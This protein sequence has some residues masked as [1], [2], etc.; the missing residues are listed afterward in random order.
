[1]V[2]GVWVLVLLP[3]MNLLQYLDWAA[4]IPVPEIFDYRGSVG[5]LNRTLLA[6]AGV[7]EALIFCMGVVLLFSKERK[8][9]LN[10]LEWTRRWGVLCSYILLL[11][12]FTGILLIGSLVLVGITALFLSMPLQYQPRITSLL[13]HVS[14]AYLSY[15]PYPKDV[16]AAVQVGFSSVMMLFACVTLFDALRSS[17]GKAW[18]LALVGPLA[19]FALM[20]LAVAGGYCLGILPDDQVLAVELY[21]NP[22]LLFRSFFGFPSNIFAT[23]TAI[24]FFI[25]VAKWCIV[26]TIAVWLTV[27]QVAAWRKAPEPLDG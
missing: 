16:T 17:A 24:P 5:T 20:N 11:L 27:A 25:E 6:T 9:R 21:F 12:S 18:A 22:E 7:Y 19:F 2:A 1:M 26:F 14:T 23:G 4:R 10:R 13:L 15:G 3:L 8:R